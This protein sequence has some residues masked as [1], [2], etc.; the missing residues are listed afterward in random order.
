MDI[1]RPIVIAAF[2][3][4]LVAVTLA[5]CKGCDDDERTVTVNVTEPAAPNAEGMAPTA[6]D[7]PAAADAPAVEPYDGP[8]SANA[9]GFKLTSGFANGAGESVR[10]PIALEQNRVFVTVLDDGN[11]PIGTLSAFDDAE[12]HAFLIARDMRQTYYAQASGSIAPGADA[13]GFDFEPREGGDHALVAAFQPN[14]GTLQAVATPVVIRG[15]L[16]QVA[17]PGVA[18]L[19][20][21]MRKSGGDAELVVEP[22]Q[23]SEGSEMTLRLTRRELGAKATTTVGLR[24][25]VVCTAGIGACEVLSAGRDGL[26]H[27]TPT[28]I[29]HFVMLIP[30]A[31]A[32]PE[33]AAKDAALA[34]EALAFGIGVM[35]KTAAPAVPAAAPAMPAA[36]PAP[37]VAP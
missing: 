10:Q 13:R 6:D 35:P 36:A 7:P 30:A 1:R 5:G 2:A 26:L 8:T 31:H 33:A 34:R 4:L 23:P 17:G 3:V 32:F 29:G 18:D 14:G 16:P 24:W 21:T 37:G 25:A 28:A 19:T 11:H 12:V 9:S 20:R 27:W 15:N 22:L